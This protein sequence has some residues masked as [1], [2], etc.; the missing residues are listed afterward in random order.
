MD[1]KLSKGNLNFRVYTAKPLP[2]TARENDI[3]VVSDI[4]MTNW[5]LSPDAPIGKPRTD[6][7]VWIQYTVDDET[8]NVVRNGAMLLH[9]VAA[10]QYIDDAWV[11]VL[12][13]C[14]QNGT[15]VGWVNHLY[16]N[17]AV[18]N[19]ITG[20][21]VS[22]QWLFYSNRTGKGTGSIG[23]E[24]ITLRATYS[25]NSGGTTGSASTANKI[26]VTNVDKVIVHVESSTAGEV[27][28]C[29]KSDETY[30]RDNYEAGASLASKTDE[31]VVLDVSGVTGSCYIVLC[32]A[33]S[34]DV[35]S[36]S[37]TVSE[38]RCE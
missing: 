12:V 37:V 2:Q 23:K 10:Y 27:W 22:N 33:G 19:N 28:V 16:K 25:V 8:S 6:G 30:L 20:G 35:N 38:V 3:V 34:G 17:G 1:F 11:S 15:W 14:Y 26:D 5:I 24:I 18:M 7:D 9:F 21:W 31:D 29:L 4:H 32:A 36:P 13:K